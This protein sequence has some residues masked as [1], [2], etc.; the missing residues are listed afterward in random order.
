MRRFR[1]DRI[2]WRTLFNGVCLRISEPVKLGGGA[3]LSSS[4]KGLWGYTLA[5]IIIVMLV[6]AVIVAVTI[7]ITKQKLDGI[8]TYTYYSAYST[9]RSVNSQM[10]SDYKPDDERYQAQKVPPV[11]LAKVKNFFVSN[12]GVLAVNAYDLTPTL[13]GGGIIGGGSNS[14]YDTTTDAG[15]QQCLNNNRGSLGN[16]LPY[17]IKANCP[18]SWVGNDMTGSCY[19][20]K[21]GGGEVVGYSGTCACPTGFG[22][23]YNLESCV[24]CAK[25]AAPKTCNADNPCASHSATPPPVVL[26]GSGTCPSTSTT[27]IFTVQGTT[28]DGESCT[29]AFTCC[30]P[31]GKKWDGDECVEDTPESPCADKPKPPCATFCNMLTGEWQQKWCLAGEHLNEETCECEKDAV[32]EPCT[33][34]KVRDENGDCVCPP[35]KPYEQ[36]DGVCIACT[37]GKVWNGKVC[38][39]PEDKPYEQEGVCIACRDSEVWTGTECVCPSGTEWVEATGKCEKLCTD[40]KVRNEDGVCV[41]PSGT[42]WVNATGQCEPL[43][44]GDLTRN[45]T[46]GEC[47][48]TR[49]RVPDAED[50]TKCVCPDGKEWSKGQCRC[51]EGTEEVEDKCEP[52][53]T[54]GKV[55]NDNGVCVCPPDK[56]D[57]QNG[58]CV[59]TCPG[60]Q[61]WDG[62]E[63]SC[64]SGTEPF[65][66]DQ[67]LAPCEGD[68]H[69]NTVTGEC[70]CPADREKKG[71]QCVCPPD[72]TENEKGQCIT[73]IG[74]G[75][76]CEDGT[77]LYNGECVPICTGDTR[78]GPSGNCVCPAGQEAYPPGSDQ[79]VDVC[80]ANEVRNSSGRCDC[81][82][83]YERFNGVC[84]PECTGGKTRNSDGICE[85]AIDEIEIAGVCTVPEPEPSCPDGKVLK[86]DVCVCPDGQIEILGKCFGSCPGDKV[87]NESGVC[88]CP[89]GTEA[90]GSDQCLAPCTG[91]QIRTSSGGCECPDGTHLEN[92]VCKADGGIDEEPEDDCTGGQIWNGTECVCPADKPTW[93]GSECV[94]GD[95][96][97]CEDGEVWNG[98]ECV[99]AGS[100]DVCGPPP[101]AGG[102]YECNTTTHTWETMDTTCPE[103]YIWN[104]DSCSC[105]LDKSRISLNGPKYCEYT[106]SLVNTRSGSNECNGSA[107]SP[108]VTDFSNETP[109]LTLRNNMR[110]YNIRQNPGPIADLAGNNESFFIDLNGTPVKANE[111]GYTVYIDIDGA[112]SSSEL[113]VDVYPFYITLDGQ[114]IP[115]YDKAHPGI[116]GGDSRNHMQ[117]S[118]EDEV[119]DGGRR[120]IRWLDKSVS[121]KEAAC[122]AGYIG[123]NTPYCRDGNA[124][125]YNN[126][127]S[128]DN[129]FCRLK[130]IKPVKFLF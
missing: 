1:R 53:C 10:I 77:E 24:S 122:Q 4:K 29:K 32:E 38:V 81:A 14:E 99:P 112:N 71:T 39:C 129:S 109:D 105:Q 51:P 50:P 113:W 21:C 100:D 55:R 60:D 68:L 111:Y 19:E 119:I 63:C 36:A 6:I 70:V 48:C 35:D 108:G 91:G 78:R 47:V 23:S 58:V 2:S 57:E 76:D 33:G 120:R 5:E 69:R 67:C 43:C 123:A 118:I 56:P 110:I 80:S 84:V 34:G 52:L 101:P 73:D 54:G 94:A 8:V 114:V 93:T 128:V 125:A 85:C 64:P 26:G 92:G 96:D 61:V 86:N 65:G 45:Q 31:E 103:R 37:G 72:T 44:E 87:H 98:T 104:P 117:V 41:C 12:F 17:Y 7:G 82:P 126:E 25:T 124:V 130:Y 95:G 88:V 42:E 18:G 9:L 27:K 75:T 11:L 83:G 22:Y 49:G 59:P 28:D 107:I 66:K 46:T 102:C 97:P 79:C 115:A 30:C 13:P 121:Y 16:I 62:S 127:C 15:V 116:N 74:S 89:D 3:V 40:G 106:A 20:R 90:F